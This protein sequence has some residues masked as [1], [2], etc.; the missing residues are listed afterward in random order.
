M[1]EQALRVLW[2]AVCSPAAPRVGASSHGLPRRTV[3]AAAAAAA[4]LAA[5]PSSP[6]AALAAALERHCPGVSLAQL[7]TWALVVLISTVNLQLQAVPISVSPPTP[8]CRALAGRALRHCC[9]LLHSGG[10]DVAGFCF[11]MAYPL[12]ELA[13]P[14]PPDTAVARMM[15][16][17]RLV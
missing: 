12:T 5:P 15:E 9:L 14:L 1:L 3:T 2:P 4:I 13:S 16:E 10:S 6:A 8:E 17:G 7:R 11:R